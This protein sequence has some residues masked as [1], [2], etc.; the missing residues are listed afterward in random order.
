MN[1]TI[2]PGDLVYRDKDWLIDHV[3]ICIEP[4]KILH[5]VPGQLLTIV[6]LETYVADTVVKVVRKGNINGRR[7]KG[8]ATQL[9]SNPKPYHFLLN[10]CEHLVSYLLYGERRS[11]QVFAAVGGAVTGAMLCSDKGLSAQ[12][13]FMAMG[14]VF[15]LALNNGLR[16]H[17]FE[18][19]SQSSRP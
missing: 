1:Q 15:G 11:Q 10:N 8:R 18:Y 12:L 17:Q 5:N 7:L 6:A 14:A 9:L 2:M 19:Q 3:G 4:G 16:N 13:K